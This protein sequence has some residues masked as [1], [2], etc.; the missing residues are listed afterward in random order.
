MDSQYRYCLAS[1]AQCYMGSGLPQ[2]AKG[3]GM[4][5]RTSYEIQS[6]HA[7]TIHGERPSPLACTNGEGH[8]AGTSLASTTE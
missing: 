7:G 5:I 8:T 2:L 3:P 4:G 1:Y 6:T